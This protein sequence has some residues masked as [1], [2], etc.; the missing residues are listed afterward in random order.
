MSLPSNRGYKAQHAKKRSLFDKRWKRIGFAIVAVVLSVALISGGTFGALWLIGR[1]SL[2]GGDGAN[3]VPD[4]LEVEIDEDGSTVFYKGHTYVY[5]KNLTSV[6]FIGTDRMGANDFGNVAGKNG[7]AD[8]LY[9]A[10]IDT[11][12]GKSTI[13][14]I[15]RDI[16]T[17]VRVF[18]VT[19]EYVGVKK[20]QVC[21]AFAYGDGKEK[22]CENTLQTVSNLL[23]GV[24]ISTYFCM[25]WQ[26]IV[27]LNDAVGGV[28]VPEYD[29]NWEK[30]GKTVTLKGR[31]A[32]DY[33]YLRNKEDLN[34]S[35]NRLE[36]QVNY[37]K[38]FAEKTVQRTKNDITTPIKLYNKLSKNAINNLDASKITYLTTVFMNGGAQLEFRTLTGRMEQGEEFAEMYLDDT[39]TYEMLLEV[40]YNKI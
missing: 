23:Y 36:R 40:F 31:A 3:Q 18:S 4:I 7:Q 25:D 33:I 14:A 16:M 29:A 17:D 30:T 34:S 1:N 35:T 26:N 13:I 24:D 9:L 39:K 11:A 22:S 27:D 2:T 6:L 10:V 38:S 12:T 21:L 37:M 28:D 5:N 8:A 19:G 20:M 32:L 15:S